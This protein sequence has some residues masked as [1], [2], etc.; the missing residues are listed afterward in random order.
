MYGLGCWPRPHQQPAHPRQSLWIY[1]MLDLDLNLRALPHLAFHLVF[2]SLHLLDEHP[3]L[4]T[5]NCLYLVGR[6]PL[7]RNVMNFVMR[8]L[9]LIW[10]QL[11]MLDLDLNLRV[12]L[13]SVPLVLLNAHC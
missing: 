7:L 11:E 13:L 1:L 4:L 12:C 3:V 2:H 6:L 9:F 5:G 10:L 8:A